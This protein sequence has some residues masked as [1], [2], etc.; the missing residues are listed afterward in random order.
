MAGS[1]N[2]SI[3]LDYNATAPIMPEVR[4]VMDEIME[5]PHNPSSVHRAGR[6]AKALLERN[7]RRLAEHLSCWPGELVFTSSGTEANIWR[8]GD[9]LI[10][11]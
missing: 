7:R 4:A 10:I 3:Y 8:C 1:R 9:W 5:R 6:A 2:Q 11:R